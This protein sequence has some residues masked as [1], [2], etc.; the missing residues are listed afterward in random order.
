MRSAIKDILVVFQG[1][2]LLSLDMNDEEKSITYEFRKGA[3]LKIDNEVYEAPEDRT[4]LKKQYLVSD[5][6]KQACDA[7]KEHSLEIPKIT[8]KIHF[9][10][11]PGFRRGLERNDINISRNTEATCWPTIQTLL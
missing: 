6:Y 11:Y 10:E 9:Q 2:D 8:Y 3:K 1:Q 4:P 5:H 7:L